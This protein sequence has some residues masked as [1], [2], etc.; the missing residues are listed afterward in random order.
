M[1]KLDRAHMA[2]KGLPSGRPSHQ[3]VVEKLGR[4]RETAAPSTQERQ[5]LGDRGRPLSSDDN[6]LKGRCE[7]S[8]VAMLGPVDLLENCDRLRPHSPDSLFLTAAIC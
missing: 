4:V 5:I 8:H 1:C 6:A 2:K 7:P 3:L